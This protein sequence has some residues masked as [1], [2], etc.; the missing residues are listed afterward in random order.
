MTTDVIVIGGGHNGL[1]AAA[2]IARAGLPTLVLERRDR[3]GGA[4]VT[5]EF[6]P[7]FRAPTV[8][9]L[10]GP[11][12]PS[13]L[14]DLGLRVATLEP[15]PR[16]YAPRPD[17]PGLRLF[18]DPERTSAEIAPLSARDADR[19]PEFH[20]ALVRVGRVLSRIA[21]A[22][23]PDVSRPA[24]GDLLPLVRVAV[25]IR[26]LGRADAE[27]LLRW[28]PMAVADFAGE[29]FEN[30][31]LRAM[32]AARGI[33]G[34]FAGPWSGGTTA[35]L[36]LNAALTGSGGAGSTVAVRGG[37]GAI[38]EALADAARRSGARIRTEAQVERILVTNG[39]ASGVVLSDGE[40]I[41]ARAVVSG[42]HPK[43]TFL[44][45]LD[46]ALL[47]PEDARRARGY[48]TTG[49]ASK[50]NLALSGL[51]EFTSLR[52]RD[53]RESL[54]GRIHI[55]PS[56]DEMERAFDDAKHG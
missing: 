56:V 5:E 25:G 48:Q 31:L 10:A 51:P 50:V 37:V 42:A 35:P 38:S 22:T 29:W 11:L 49:M 46:P 17:G 45:L 33:I 55:G 15:E 14:R 30:D 53:P 44:S 9:H 20:A 4:A 24:L 6:H 40:E 16:V 54:G 3:V 2:Y 7:G 47:D 41:P 26:A 8:A 52:G 34:S 27:N 21:E 39:R 32:V 43:T 13:I 19:Y 18:G 12:R 36:L 28:G 23:P 1:V